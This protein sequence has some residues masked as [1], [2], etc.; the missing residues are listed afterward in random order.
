MKDICILGN[1][2]GTIIFNDIFLDILME[3]QLSNVKAINIEEYKC[4]WKKY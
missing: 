4:P 3:N 1:L 2:P